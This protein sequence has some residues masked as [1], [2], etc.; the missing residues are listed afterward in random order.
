M[1]Q[2]HESARGKSEGRK[3]PNDNRLSRFFRGMRGLWKTRNCESCYTVA[4]ASSS[5]ALALVV[6]VRVLKD[7][8]GK[9]YRNAIPAVL[10]SATSFRNRAL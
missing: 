8:R 9:P 10:G 1:R 2:I 7:G 4:A 5:I 6:L 3:T